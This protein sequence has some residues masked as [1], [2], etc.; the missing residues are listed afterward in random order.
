MPSTNKHTVV[1][2]GHNTSVFVE[3]DFWNELKKIS[4]S[5][6]I[7]LSE[8][9]ALIDQNKKKSNLSSAIRLYILNHLREI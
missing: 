7:S 9:I 8:M 6:N 3:D 2:N 5:K 4:L 1:I